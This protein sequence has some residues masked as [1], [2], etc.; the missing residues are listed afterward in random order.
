[1]F[2]DCGRGFESG[3]L[4]LEEFTARVIQP[5][6][7]HLAPCA[8]VHAYKQDTSFHFSSFVRTAHERQRRKCK[9]HVTLR[10][11]FFARLLVLVWREVNELLT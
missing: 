10:V 1:M 2:P 5:C 3:A 4:R 7:G 9:I 11:K 6:F 8:V